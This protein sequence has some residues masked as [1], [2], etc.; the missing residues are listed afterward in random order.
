MIKAK[1]AFETLERFLWWKKQFLMMA[2]LK[3]PKEPCQTM[4]VTCV[5]F[6][7]GVPVFVH[8]LLHHLQPGDAVSR[9]RGHAL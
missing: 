6:L 4:H 1:S 2:M 9:Q 8:S 5:F 3:L 7:P